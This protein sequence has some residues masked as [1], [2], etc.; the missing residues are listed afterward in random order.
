MMSM[1]CIMWLEDEVGGNEVEWSSGRKTEGGEHKNSSY[2]IVEH[3]R[4]DLLNSWEEKLCSS[5]TVE[6]ITLKLIL[7]FDTKPFC[8]FHG[9]KPV[10]FFV[11]RVR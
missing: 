1:D 11:F 10:L 9:L 6:K 2:E 5:K 8:K 4:K 7:F 3:N